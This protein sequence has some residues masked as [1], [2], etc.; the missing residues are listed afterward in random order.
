MEVQQF[1]LSPPT[2]ENIFTAIRRG[3]IEYVRQAL[4]NGFD[5]KLTSNRY[6]NRT[7]LHEAVRRKQ[8]GMV[9]ML[10]EEFNVNDIN[11][12]VYG[13]TALMY[14]CTKGFFYFVRLLTKPENIEISD[15]YNMTPL[16]ESFATNNFRIAKWLLKKG[17][18]FNII[19][20]NRNFINALYRDRLLRINFVEQLRRGRKL[21]IQQPIVSVLNSLTTIIQHLER[22]NRRGELNDAL[23]LHRELNNALQLYTH[24]EPQPIEHLERMWVSNSQLVAEYDGWQMTNEFTGIV[25]P[26]ERKEKKP[27]D[28]I[29][30][31]IIKN[32]IE[33]EKNCPITMTILILEDSALT[34]CYHV[35]NKDAIELW[36]VNHTTCPICREECIVWGITPS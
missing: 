17:A 30:R 25:Q 29:I 16:L 5:I 2:T 31:A 4:L 13:K 28:S 26:I 11:R 22:T 32:S 7:I 19:S 3:N 10:V 8:I 12:D 14:A 36:L 18:N 21:F 34:N 27:R 20:F 1:Q 23:Q 24:Q 9:K 6:I 33:E 15:F 35:F